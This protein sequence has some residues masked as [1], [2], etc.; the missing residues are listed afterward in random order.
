VP[1]RV[2]GRLL[3][4]LTIAG[5]VG[6]AWPHGP[7][8]QEAPA[9][10]RR[11]GEHRW[12]GVAGCAAAACHNANGRLGTKG[13]EYS[14]W[15]GYDK[16]ANAFAVLYNE[17]SK[18]M[19]RAL[20]GSQAKPAT[21]TAIC[22]KCHAMNGG[23]KEHTGDR[24]VL[25]DGVGC[26]SCHGPAG[27]WVATHYLDEFKAKSPK[28]RAQLG[29]RDTKDLLVRARLCT[30]CH[31]GTGEQDVNHDLIAAGHP[32]LNFEFA[33]FH[34]IYPKHWPEGPELQRHPDLHARLW[35]IGQVVSAEAALKL[36]AARAKGAQ[37]GAKGKPWPEFAE[38]ACYACH[39]DLQ[40]ENPSQKAGFPGR[41]P[42]DFSWGT[43]YFDMTQV[44]ADQPGGPGR[45]LDAALQKL[46]DLMQRPGPDAAAVAQGAAPVAGLLRDW[47]DRVHGGPTLPPDQMRG[48]MRAF[49]GQGARRA[50]ALDWDQ[51]AQLY[52]AL[53]AFNQ[54]LSDPP[55]EKAPATGPLRVIRQGLQ[56]AF[57]P[58][59]DSPRQFNA[60]AKEKLGQQL[61]Q[62][63]ELLGP[64]RG[65]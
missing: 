15:A 57:P 14:T 12:V 52:L 61:R 41:R 58:G 62:V 29:F 38:Y 27:D 13:S 11:D 65:R 35:E 7:A 26:E 8:A 5:A 6:L 50:N 51:V 32:R 17:R 16:H 42:G 1:G 4:G 34:G 59:Y 30:E 53:A 63:Q 45:Q 21:E 10:A 25:S 23:S 46:R 19:V 48:L 22:L 36:L 54:A 55:A 24:F 37:A 44:Y 60:A 2:Y 64:V 56:S 28:E 43:W 49:A 20:Y 47:A 31:V 9:P 18:N 33:S 40:V 39:K 3:L